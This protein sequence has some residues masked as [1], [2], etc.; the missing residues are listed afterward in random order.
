MTLR[1][2]LA[3]LALAAC[4]LFPAGP[5]QAQQADTVR[6]STSLWTLCPGAHVRLAVRAGETVAGRCGSVVDG[7][8]LVRT[9]SGERHVRL[10][11]VDSV[12]TRRSYLTEA[13]LLFAVVG[14]AVGGFTGG[15]SEH[16]TVVGCT[17]EYGLDP[18]PRA[19][20][21]AVVGAAVGAVVG[22]TITGWRRRFP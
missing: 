8:L 7:R 6:V 12:W 15:D 5:A 9:G 17:V 4:V 13:V 1:P 19:G 22:S 20:A 3:A 16:C 14:A 2:T 21:G 18:T 11:E 10:A